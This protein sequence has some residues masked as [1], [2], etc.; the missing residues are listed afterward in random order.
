MST[1]ISLN[2]HRD[3]QDGGWFHVYRETMDESV[4]LELQGARVSVEAEGPRSVTAKIPADWA[5]RLGL[6]PGNQAEQAFQLLK[7]LTKKV[8]AG[9]WTPEYRELAELI[10]TLG[11]DVFCVNPDDSIRREV[12]ADFVDEQ[13][14]QAWLESPNGWIVDADGRP[15]APKD[16]LDRP[17]DIRHA[18]AKRKGT[19]VA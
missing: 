5:Q 18:L 2:Y 19:Y 10:H 17:D 14:A 6:I 11:R 8:P 15:L 7:A 4:Y 9:Q 12:L 16:A 13:K 1:K 3:E